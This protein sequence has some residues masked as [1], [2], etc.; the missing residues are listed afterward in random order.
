MIE[1]RRYVTRAGR[2]IFSEWFAELEDASA[3]AKIRDRIDRVLQGNFG[4]SKA[5]G[6]G[7]HELRIAWGQATES[8]TQ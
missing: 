7:L 2:S 1:I 4:D 3:K 5:L 6:R 8:I